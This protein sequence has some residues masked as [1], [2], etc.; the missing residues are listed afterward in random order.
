MSF[1]EA[2]VKVAHPS[3]LALEKMTGDDATALP[4]GDTPRTIEV[5]TNLFAPDPIARRHTDG[6][7]DIVGLGKTFPLVDAKGYVL[8]DQP[9]G[10]V[11]LPEDLPTARSET[12]RVPLHGSRHDPR[13]LAIATPWSNVESVTI[14]NPP[15]LV[16]GLLASSV[17]VLCGL[18]AGAL[19][20]D[21]SQVDDRGP[22]TVERAFGL[23]LVA[24]GVVFLVVG[25]EMLATRPE[26]HAWTPPN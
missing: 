7:I 16:P 5:G 13:D 10:L 17:A 23:S 15:M 18:G 22:R 21:A 4:P 1:E 11:I 2:H 26:Q 8:S 3:E 19:L 9:Y 6:T 12:F 14:R 25:I 24:V 20:Y